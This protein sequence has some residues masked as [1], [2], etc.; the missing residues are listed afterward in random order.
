MAVT[1]P[2]ITNYDPIPTGVELFWEAAPTKKK[3]AITP[4]HWKGEYKSNES[5]AKHAKKTNAI[6]EYEI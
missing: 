4:K 2:L 3:L 1:V 6:N 5:Q